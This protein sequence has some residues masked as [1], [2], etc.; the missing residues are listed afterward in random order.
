MTDIM[1]DI[2][3]MGTKASCVVLTVAAVKF[4]PSTYDVPFEELYMKLDI[5]QQIMMDRTVD[6]STMDWWQEQ[7]ETVRLEAFGEDG[8]VNVEQALT[9]LSKFISDDNRIWAQGPTFDIVILESLYQSLNMPVPWKFYNVR[10]S[11]TL[12]A[13]IGDFRSKDD[14]SL[15]NALADCKSQV[16]GVQKCF[17][18]LNQLVDSAELSTKSTQNTKLDLT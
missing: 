16:F 2:E 12:F 17:D 6:Q 3:T 18:I 4:N 5:N 8:R 10:D 1:I 11:R 15:H 13:L 7:N 14:G 9:S